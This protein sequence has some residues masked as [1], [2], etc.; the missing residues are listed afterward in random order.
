MPITPNGTEI[1]L[2]SKPF[3]RVDWR[4]TCPRGSGRSATKRAP[5]AMPATR[6]S[7]R[8]KRSCIC[9]CISSAFA[10]AI[11]SPFALRISALRDSIAAAMAY[12]AALRSA[13]VAV[14]RVRAAV[15]ALSANSETIS[16]ASIGKV[17]RFLFIRGGL[18][19]R[20]VRV[21]ARIQRPVLRQVL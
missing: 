11:S 6:D 4:R 7:V 2:R 14:E 9:G 21:H 18:N 3:G 15:R 16:T 10:R 12:K 1:C 17:Y 20:D 19:H 13:P 8:S 5:F